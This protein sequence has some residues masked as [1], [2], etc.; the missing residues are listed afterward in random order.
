MLEG[1]TQVAE[2][3]H[4]EYGLTDNVE[5]RVENEKI[6]SEKSSKQNMDLRSLPTHAYLDQ[7]CCACKGKTTK[8]H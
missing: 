3:Q 1:Q 8:S 7:L 6:N 4:S 2:S 5:R